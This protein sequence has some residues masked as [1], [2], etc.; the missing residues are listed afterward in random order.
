MGNRGLTDVAQGVAKSRVGPINE[1]DDGLA[2]DQNVTGIEITVT[3]RGGD[4]QDGRGAR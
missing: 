1:P 2:I 4:S 3:N